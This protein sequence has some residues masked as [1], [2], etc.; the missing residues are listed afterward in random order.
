[1]TRP[2]SARS[3][4]LLL[5]FDRDRHLGDVGAAGDVHDFDDMAVLDAVVGV[6]D[7]QHLGVFRKLLA[8]RFAQSGFVDRL[9]VEK[10]P[11]VFVDGDRRALG[12]RLLAGQRLWAD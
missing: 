12:R 10:Q 2:A 8:Q 6:D 7:D 5:R 3:F 4:F 1:M 9:L 11:A